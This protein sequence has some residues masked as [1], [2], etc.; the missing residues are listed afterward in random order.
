MSKEKG[1]KKGKAGKTVAG[2]GILALIASLF[3]FGAW[4]FGGGFGSGN[5]NESGN[6][7]AVQ[8]GRNEEINENQQN[9]EEQN[10]TAAPTATVVPTEKPA[11]EGVT[12]V[13]L[14]EV[15]VMVSGNKI[16]YNG[17]E[18]ESAQKLVEQLKTE[19]KGKAEKILVKVL[20][21]NAVYDTVEELKTALEEKK[22]TYEITE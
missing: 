18:A 16:M 7:T 4:G 12:M 22:M 19:Y 21:S 11:E 17:E 6:G 5:G 8:E 1:K 3:G 9:Q 14:A 15:S 10:I 2:A 13:E 20:L